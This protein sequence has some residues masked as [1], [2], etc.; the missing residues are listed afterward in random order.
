GD[1]VGAG[2]MAEVFRGTMMGAEGIS[3]PVAVK[4]VLPGLSTPQFVS[5][6]IQ[7]AQLAAL[8]KH[9]NIVT[10]LDFDRDPDGRLFLVMEY[11][12]GRDLAT[13]VDTGLLP[14]STVNFVLS[15]ILCGLGY[16]HELPTAGPVRGLVHRDVSPHNVLLSWEGAV[17]VSD[18]GIAKAREASAATAS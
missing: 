10:I 16:A 3:L 5:M 14:F 13:L 1:R 4:C 7:E 9:P 17:K 11:V 6:F 15:E 18:F 8:L 2:G 12:E